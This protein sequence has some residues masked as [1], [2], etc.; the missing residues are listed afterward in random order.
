MKRKYIEILIA[1]CGLVSTAVGICIN[2]TGVFYS[3]VSKDLGLNQGT[4]SMYETISIFSAA[5]LTIFTSRF[6]TEKNFKKLIVIGTFLTGIST[7]MMSL[8]SH[9][10]EFYI[11]GFFMGLGKSIY[12]SI[13]VNVIINN[14]FISYHGFITGF[15]LGFSGIA[16]SLFSPFFSS[17]IE[18]FGWRIAY[19]VMGCSIFVLNIPA[20]LFKYCLKPEEMDM[21]PFFNGKKKE[22][23]AMENGKAVPCTIG[24]MALMMVFCFTATGLTGFPQNIPA[25]IVSL[26][27]PLSA[28]ALASSFAQIGNVSSKAIFGFISDLIGPVKTIYIMLIIVVIS[29]GILLTGNNINVLLIGA[30][31]YGFIYSVSAVSPTLIIKD[32][33]GLEQYKKIFPV[34]SFCGNTGVALS[35]SMFGFVYE[36]YQSFKPDFLIIAA[37][38]A[39]LGIGITVIDIIT[40]KRKEKIYGTGN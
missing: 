13:L 38:L 33:F 9:P 2:S 35:V 37:G 1:M 14:W 28:G 31:V 25:Y 5:F 7:M 21:K 34:T 12:Y 29:L 40:N 19:V 17:I 26:G 39:V 18:K 32:K 23:K 22:E 24:L 6:V 16:G 30:L 11:L 20:V 10:V 27:F 8:F 36:S 3:P 4:F 15:V